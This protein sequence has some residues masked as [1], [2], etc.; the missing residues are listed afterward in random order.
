[1][2]IEGGNEVFELFCFQRGAIHTALHVIGLA[3]SVPGLLKTYPIQ[4]N[5]RFSV[6]TVAQSEQPHG[7]RE[8]STAPTSSRF[9][10]LINESN[11]NININESSTTSFPG[12]CDHDFLFRARHR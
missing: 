11:I 10:T 5:K 2:E 9:E 7:A 8:T 4:K 1:M 12:E 6:E 3:S